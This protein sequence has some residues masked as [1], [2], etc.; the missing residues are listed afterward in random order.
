MNICVLFDM[1]GV[2]IDTEPQYSAFWKG[3]AEEYNIETINFENKVKGMTIPHII[4]LYFN[5]LSS[6]QVENILNKFKTFEEN[7]LF[8]DIPGALNFLDELRYRGIKIALVTSS[9]ELKL[10]RVL[11]LKH[12]DTIFDVIVSAKDIENSKPAPDCFLLGAKKCNISPEF[13]IVF[14]D[15]LAGITA[16]NTA[17]MIVVGLSTTHPESELIDKCVKVIPDFRDISVEYLI[18]LIPNIGK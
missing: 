2:L 8:P 6:S 1:D 12:F 7:V 5:Q 10:N 4:K 18:S 13:C 16:G 15:S 3:I 11:Q 17:G 14:E 9:S